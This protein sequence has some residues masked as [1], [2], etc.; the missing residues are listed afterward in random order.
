ELK[1]IRRR[2]YAEVLTTKI[3]KSRIILKRR[4][5]PFTRNEF[6]G[7][8]VEFPGSDRSVVQR[9]QYY[10][11]EHFNEPPLQIQTYFTIPTFT[12]LIS[13][14]LFAAMFAV[15]TA[16]SFGSRL[17]SEYPEFFTA[18]AFSKKGP[19]RTQ[20]ESTRFC[21]T[22][23]G[24]GWSKRVLEQQSNKQN[25]SDV[26]PDTE[27]DETIMVKVSG[28]D[29]GYM[30]TSTCLVQSGLTILMESDKIPRG[31]LTPAS[32]FRDT[33]LLDR[34]SERDFTIEVAQIE[35]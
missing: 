2:L 17:L 8:N 26:E 12:N 21:T 25:D 9:T 10:N 22:I 23:I 11:Y 19:S 24:R 15:M 34:L 28:R 20:I 33:K 3:P 5:L 31:V 29:P 18:G 35:N 30:A 4:T 32:A 1:A 14:I 16:T 27:P 7:W 6:S 13:M